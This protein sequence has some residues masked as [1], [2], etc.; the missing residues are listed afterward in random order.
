[1]YLD[2]LYHL[3]NFHFGFSFY[4][5]AIDPSDFIASCQYPIQSCWGVIKNLW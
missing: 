1:M 3:G 5:F 2:S 4:W